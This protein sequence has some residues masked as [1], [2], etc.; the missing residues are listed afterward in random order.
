MNR[1]SIAVLVA[2]SATVAQAQELKEGQWEYQ[3]TING[4]GGGPQLTAEQRAKIEAAKAQM[5][6]GFKIPGME[7]GAGGGITTTFKKCVT[8]EDLVP[9]QR[10]E[11]GVKCDVTKQERSGNRVEFAAHCKGNGTDM[12]SDGWAEYSGTSMKSEVKARGTTH[13]QPVDMSINTTGKYLGACG[14]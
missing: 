9:P 6:P 4:A 11:P 12:T 10:E 7:I 13:G 5:P 2:L 14:K 8:K 3:T 1:L